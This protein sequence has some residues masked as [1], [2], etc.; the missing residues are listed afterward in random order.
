MKNRQRGFTLVEL[1]V[2][3]AIIAM[4]VLLLL[5]AVQAARE[6]ARR[7]QCMNHIRNL[8]LGFINHE[9]AQGFFPSAGWPDWTY[10]MTYV[11]GV[12]AIAPEQHGGWGFQILPYVEATEVWMGPR[13]ATDLEK[14]IAA[15]GTPLPIMFCP[16]RREPEVVLAAD[17]YQN[18]NSGKTF[19]HAKN[20][21]AA[22]S[23]DV[24]EKFP[25]G[26]GIVTQVEPVAV[27]HVSD[28]LSKTV[29]L[30]E[31]QMNIQL[32][33]QMQ[34]NDNE[35]YTCGWN[36]D[37]MRFTNREPRPD[38]RHPGNPGDD[39]FGSSHPGGFIVA[40]GDVSVDY[41]SYEM[42]LEVFRRLGHRRDGLPVDLSR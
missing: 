10:H 40:M 5:P 14:S 28:G 30:G 4:L 13:G 11:K 6:S 8:A 25:R 16:S 27:N 12:P 15:I 33:G 3:I 37:I 7:T 36:H 17:W 29:M 39:R 38:F 42:E 21:Y 19:G 34:A 22:A 31:K 41:L 24:S 23:H 35:G 32:L 20:D 18:P 1:L 2:V 9:S 26:I